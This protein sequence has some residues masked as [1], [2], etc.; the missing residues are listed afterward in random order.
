[1]QLNRDF[2]S[3]AKSYPLLRIESVVHAIQSREFRA[4]QKLF[5]ILMSRPRRGTQGFSFAKFFGIKPAVDFVPPPRRHGSKTLVLDLDETLIHSAEF[6][7]HPQVDSIKVGYPEFYVFKR[8]GLDDFLQFSSSLF[9]TFIFTYSDRGY[10]DPILDQIC[11]SIAPDHR[12]YRDHCQRKKHGVHKDLDIFQR[13]ESELILVDDNPSTLQ[14]H[15]K[16]TILIQKWEGTPFDHQLI[17]WLPPI[18]ELCA[19]A[20]D[21]RS[22]IA[23]IP[24]VRRSASEYRPRSSLITARK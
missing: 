7:G 17:D 20:K 21:V 4:A 13:P 12:L 9:E 10:A 18:L 5:F 23:G 6:P 8:P 3:F 1:M 19:S 22:V 2:P 14:F 15:P 11:P 16:N 24:K